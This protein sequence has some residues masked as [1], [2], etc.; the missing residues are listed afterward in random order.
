M[1]K[2]YPTKIGPV[3]LI[4]LALVLGPVTVQ[5]LLARHW[6]ALLINV[7]VIGFIIHLLVTTYYLIKERTLIVRSSLFYNL[8]IPVDQIVEIRPTNNPLAA[9]AASLDRLEIRYGQQASIMVSPRDKED[10]V[11]TLRA[12][13]P[14][15]VFRS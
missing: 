3:I 12:M 11:R 14:R 13:N 2:R 7:L 6:A 15:I 10:F 9:P 4:V 8:H 1:E 5:L